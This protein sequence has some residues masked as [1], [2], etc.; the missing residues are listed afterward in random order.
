MRPASLRSAQ[1]APRLYS[2]L[3]SQA[4]EGVLGGQTAP[5]SSTLV[6]AWVLI[7]FRVAFRVYQTTPKTG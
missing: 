2:A 6:T 5:L 7:M 4:R 3:R 1:R